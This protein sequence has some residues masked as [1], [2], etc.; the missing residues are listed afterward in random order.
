MRHCESSSVFVVM[1]SPKN[2]TYWLRALK[3]DNAENMHHQKMLKNDL[4]LKKV[5]IV[6]KRFEESS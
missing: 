3:W 2:I 4:F 6:Q 5:F 1:C